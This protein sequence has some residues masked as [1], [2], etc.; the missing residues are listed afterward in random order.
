MERYL[1]FPDEQ[2]PPRDYEDR[3]NKMSSRANLCATRPRLWGQTLDPIPTRQKK[4]NWVPYKRAQQ[5]PYQ[6]ID[7]LRSLQMT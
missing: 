6:A 4:I 7:G 2:S 1:P 5:L 3:A